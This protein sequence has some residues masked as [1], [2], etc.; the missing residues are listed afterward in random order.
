MAESRGP[1][2]SS[3]HLLEPLCGRHTPP[4][5]GLHTA[6]SGGEPSRDGP[7]HPPRGGGRA[8]PAP[9]CW[10]LRRYLLLRRPKSPV[11]III[12]FYLDQFLK[13]VLNLFLFYVLVF[14]PRGLW[15]LSSPTRV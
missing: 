15:G 9:E 8:R 3:G 12:F 5:G 2:S 1:V 4:L 13:S 6:S 10:E 14:W 11:I 7:P